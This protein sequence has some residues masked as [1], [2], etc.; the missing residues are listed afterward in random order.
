LAKVAT[1]FYDGHAA[2]DR[3]YFAQQVESAV[4]RAVIHQNHF[5]G[6]A[7]GFH[8]GLQPGIQIGDVLLFIVE[9]NYD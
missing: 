9:R 3:G 1:Q 4:V 8:D 7:A 6:L 2:I 5:E